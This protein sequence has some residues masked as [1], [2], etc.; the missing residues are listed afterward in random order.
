MIKIL[1][2]GSYTAE[3]AKALI[4]AGGSSRKAAV[5]KML[6]GLGGKLEAFYFALGHSD[7][8]VIAEVPDAA[9]IAAVTLTVNAS[10]MVKISTVVLM[11]PE[12]VDAASKKSVAYRPPGG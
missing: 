8:Y 7:L 9:A 6:E 12:E 1:I 3:G 11:T 5:E 4:K 10:A 2:T